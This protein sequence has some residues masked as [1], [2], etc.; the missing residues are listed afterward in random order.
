VTG[1]H[2]T[3]PAVSRTARRLAVLPYALQT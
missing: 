2:P 1:R 3:R